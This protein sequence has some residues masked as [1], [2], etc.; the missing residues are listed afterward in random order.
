MHWNMRAKGLAGG[1]LDRVLQVAKK[2]WS[3]K[4]CGGQS[5]RPAM[6]PT[7]T[8]RVVAG[9]KHSAIIATDGAG[10]PPRDAQ[11]GHGASLLCETLAGALRPGAAEGVCAGRHGQGG[12]TARAAAPG[13][14]AEAAGLASEVGGVHDGGVAR[15]AGDRDGRIHGGKLGRGHSQ[16][17]AGGAARQRASSGGGLHE[18]TAAGLVCQGARVGAG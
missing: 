17:E 18:I 5:Q 15:L 16:H 11:D 10:V 13:G 6:Q 3:T 14:S 9:A 4:H 12:G 7:T 8:H 2:E 1:E